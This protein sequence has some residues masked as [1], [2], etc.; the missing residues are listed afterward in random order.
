MSWSPRW[1]RCRA[2]R[3]G[4]SGS[5]KLTPGCS[6]SVLT[7]QDLVQGLTPDAA[8]HSLAVG[9]HP[10]SLGCALEDL[11]LLGL[12]DGVEGL[13]VLAVAV[14]QQEPQ[15]SVRLPRLAVT[16]R[17]CCTARSRVGWVVTPAMCRRRV[18]CSGNASAYIRLPSAVSR[19]KKS[20]AMMP[21]AWAVRNSRQV[22]PVRRGAGSMPAAW[23]IA[24]TVDAAIG[25][26]RRASSP[27]IRLWPHPTPRGVREAALT[28]LTTGRPA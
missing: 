11:H 7:R 6:R 21:S 19:W 12:E 26:Q 17:A 14:A 13:P 22:G 24:Q 20:T 23:R 27:W 25:C 15:D 1:P 18:P 10:G 8:D 3:G 16:F 2:T 4:R 28:A 9:V 5:S